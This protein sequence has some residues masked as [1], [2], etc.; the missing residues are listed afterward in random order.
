MEILLAQVAK[1]NKIRKLLSI[2]VS[3]NQYLKIVMK[4]TEGKNAHY[5]LN[6]DYLKLDNYCYS[7]LNRFIHSFARCVHNLD[8]QNGFNN[9]PFFWQ[10]ISDLQIIVLNIEKYPLVIASQFCD[11]FESSVVFLIKTFGDIDED[12]GTEF[13]LKENVTLLAFKLFQQLKPLP[14]LVKEYHPIYD[15]FK[16]IQSTKSNEDKSLPLKYRLLVVLLPHLIKSF[17]GN[18]VF[19]QT[20]NTNIPFKLTHLEEYQLDFTTAYSLLIVEYYK[21]IW[22]LLNKQDVLGFLSIMETLLS[23]LQNLALVVKTN[24]SIWFNFDHVLKI[25]AVV[26]ITVDEY[27]ISERLPYNIQQLVKLVADGSFIRFDN[28]LKE[29]E[30]WLLND[31]LYLFLVEKLTLVIFKNLIRINVVISQ[32]N[33]LYFKDINTTLAFSTGNKIH[34]YSC[35]ILKNILSVWSQNNGW[36]DVFETLVSLNLIKGNVVYKLNLVLLINN[37]AD[38]SS[39]NVIF[40]RVIDKMR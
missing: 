6:N 23:K 31:Q 40:P 35:T 15:N 10:Y 14:S 18:K 11:L 20:L 29:N 1:G 3:D 13:S 30:E 8:L 34:S 32:S 7:H 21:A 25:Y 36:L 24:D 38:R 27:I 28:W 12:T 37:G 22:L 4:K 16:S 9:V 19:L 5:D 39:M 33:K 2:D 26:K 17:Q